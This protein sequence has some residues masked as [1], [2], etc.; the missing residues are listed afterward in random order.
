MTLLHLHSHWHQPLLLLLH[1]HQQDRHL[2]SPPLLST[3]VVHWQH[4]EA[5]AAAVGKGC[6]HLAATAAVDAH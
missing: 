4:A 6:C 2:R 3:T 1:R 5:E